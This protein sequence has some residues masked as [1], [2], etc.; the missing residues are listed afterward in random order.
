LDFTWWIT[1]INFI[2][3][4]ILYLWYV[5]FINISQRESVF[6]GLK[7]KFIVLEYVVPKIGMVIIQTQCSEKDREGER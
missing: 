5:Y 3:F 7:C 4:W 6:G 1:Y 2:E